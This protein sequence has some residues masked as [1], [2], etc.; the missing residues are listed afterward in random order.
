[1]V[2]NYA[3]KQFVQFI[4]DDIGDFVKREEIDILRDDGQQ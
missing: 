3:T 2:K 4:R 1:M